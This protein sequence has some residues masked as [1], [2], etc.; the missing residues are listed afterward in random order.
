MR[1]Q[2][3]AITFQNNNH[4]PSER[5][6]ANPAFRRGEGDTTKWGA[7]KFL[8]QPAWARF[9]QVTAL[10]FSLF[11]LG[12]PAP[13]AD[14]RSVTYNLDISAQDLN[15]ALQAL[16]IASQHKL[17]YSSEL[18][19][20]KSAPAV[21]G[22]LTTEQAVRQL[23][24]GT[25]LT[26]EISD[27]LVLI[28]SKD[29]HPFPTAG[30]NSAPRRGGE[31][32][33]RE[34]AGKGTTAGPFRLAQAE[35]SSQGSKSAD[36]SK[37]E[38]KSPSE[39]SSQG[40][41]E[42]PEAL[43][44]VLVTGSHI[45]RSEFEMATPVMTVDSETIL[46]SGFTSVGD[47]LL[48]TPSMGVG[49]G[50][51][52]RGG[53]GAAFVNLRGL[54]TNRSLTLVN[55][56]RRVSGSKAGSAVDLNSIPASMVDRIEVV[57]GGSSAV[58]GA[59]AI[60]GVANVILREDFEGLEL[61]TS[62]GL[63]QEGGAENYSFSLHGGTLF[64]E[65]RGSISFGASYLKSEP[66]LIK[67]RDYDISAIALDNPA[68]T[69]MDDEPLGF[70]IR[71]W[72]FYIYPYSG[73]FNV[74][75]TLYT[76]DDGG[77]RPVI[78][79]PGYGE[80]AI[81][82]PPTRD[83]QGDYFGDYAALRNESEIASFRTN[84]SYA[85]TD[86]IDF[87]AEAEFTAINASDIGSPNLF[88]D[89]PLT[90][91]N[92]LLPASLTE[93]MDANGV[94]TLSV[95]KRALDHGVRVTES[96]RD[97]YTVVGGLKGEFSNNW[98]WRFSG[99][100]G[101]YKIDSR[102]PHTTILPNYFNAIDV[103][104]DPVSGEPV[105]RDPLARAAGCVPLN[106][107]G[108]GVETPEALAYVQH[109]RLQSTTNTQ[110]IFSA[111]LTG[112]LMELPAGSLDFAFGVDSR[113]ETISIRDDGLAVQGLL[114]RIA[115][116]P[117]LDA[118][119]EVN[120]AYVELLA[121]IVADKPFVHE[122]NVEG[123]VRHS[124]YDTIGGTT[125]WK[126][127]AGWAPIEDLRFRY[128]LSQ[129]VRAPN[130]NELFTPGS[131][132][133]TL[134][135]DPCQPSLQN[136]TPNRAANCRALGIPEGLPLAQA[137]SDGVIATGGNPNLSEEQ[138]DSFTIGMVFS[139][140][141]IEGLQMSV[142]YWDFRITE[143]VQNLGEGVVERCVDASSINNPFCPL[144]TR[145]SDWTIERVD[146]IDINVSELT[147]RGIDFQV[148]YA[149]KALTGL[150]NISLLGTNLLEH[151]SL[152]DPDD[153]LTL[154]PSLDLVS[155]PD[156]RI[157][158]VT[159]FE[160]GSWSFGMTNR[161][162]SSRTLNNTFP[163]FFPPEDQIVSSA[164][165]TDIRAT[166]ELNDRYRFYAGINNVTETEPPADWLTGG[167]GGVDDGALADNVGRFF[168]GGMT[169]NF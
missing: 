102:T 73:A 5:I 87:F 41:S 156:L 58:Y 166:F 140:S 127:G 70:L 13:A 23:L 142:D 49:T 147:A 114:N 74:G 138:S 14:A 67:D 130:L 161:Y 152:V 32:I 146:V 84:M 154:V 45:A 155:H 54:G 141:A 56:S 77:L 105:C 33:L 76:V 109:T 112:D 1:T 137:D 18:V 4:G 28:R 2:S 144:V 92:P 122:L 72:V 24:T 150:W 6:R 159:G 27:G 116:E 60:S 42:S 95:N 71:D 63:S 34:G 55:G 19:D 96:D 113:T 108:R 124:D 103:I 169:I 65:D 97:T 30:A 29:D 80:G 148:A 132:I 111:L 162:I 25:N 21:K 12:F 3:S 64:S 98:K 123:A 157:N 153:P 31:G 143:A 91:D 83:P 134:F 20:G 129:S 125:A 40:S 11:F 38:N 86:R 16:A 131:L 7:R 93:L 149:F 158:L 136:A 10:L 75:D 118:E 8:A 68:Y 51:A 90:R 165:Y 52:T 69:G 53:N 107:L 48:Q 61:H 151:E 22:E 94:D 135:L 66:L 100:Y 167:G 121:P 82:V 110:H 88:L 79:T 39:T 164:I 133:S 85:V 44:E 46:Q 59:D 160:K 104:A 35:N 120:E 99:Q 168:H 78:F 119:F 126:L 37:Q 50:T 101:E 117:A 145:G 139:P 115:G 15:D 106:I 36:S 89:S 26:Y 9:S 43:E 128:T 62:G 163:N 81:G 47:V 17:L 57:T